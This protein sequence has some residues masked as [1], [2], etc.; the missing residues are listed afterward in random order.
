LNLERCE[1]RQELATTLARR[2]AQRLREGLQTR[3]A[4]S[5][6]LSGGSTP[7]RFLEALREERL[8]WKDVVVTLTDERWVDPRDSAS[9]EAMVHR[10]LLVG[11]AAAARFVS[12]KSAGPS[13]LAGREEVAR[14]LADVPRPFDFVVAGMGEDAHTASIFPGMP[15]V[16]RALRRDNP[17]RVMPA[18][19][20][21]PPHARIT[22]TL[23]ALADCR[24]LALLIH[25]SAKYAILEES[26]DA[27]R[28]HAP[29]VALLEAVG[30][31]GRV[32]WAP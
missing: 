18:E 22:L 17:E 23:A 19:A 15:G 32:F 13:P 8:N 11:E 20:P 7:V 2:V 12:L 21:A 6:V 4:A 1:D 9:N 28:S 27:E 24:E 25:G 31:R 30:D 3:G 5:L 26:R 10:C 16:D 14:R 29:V